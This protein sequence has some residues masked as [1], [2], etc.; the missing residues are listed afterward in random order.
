[1]HSYS[2]I[3]LLKFRRFGTASWTQSV[4]L[5][6]RYQPLYMSPYL[7]RFPPPCRRMRLSFRS[8]TTLQTYILMRL[9]PCLTQWMPRSIT[10]D[11]MRTGR[12]SRPATLMTWISRLLLVL[13]HRPLTPRPRR[14][15]ALSLPFI[16][17]S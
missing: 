4:T 5:Q 12:R 13:I 3:V 8:S 10:M 9:Q 11:S 6:H 14:L 15:Q 17:Q 16:Q 7:V 1:M 2:I